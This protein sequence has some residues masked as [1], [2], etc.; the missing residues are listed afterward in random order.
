[1]K[2]IFRFLSLIYRLLKYA[3]RKNRYYSYQKKYKFSNSVS[4]G[5]VIMTG[6]NIEIG[7]NTY[8][9]SG[10]ISSGVKSKIKIGNWCAIGYNVKIIAITHDTIKS[11]GPVNERP[12]KER[13]IT[14]GDN[15]WI[16]SN[17][18]I[19]EGVFIEDNSIVGA[20]SLVTKNVKKDEIVGGV[21]AKHIKFKYDVE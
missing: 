20:N 5:D 7:N 3:D 1:M 4:L 16:G 18:F 21:P 14:I 15:V 13:D 12:I 8:I 17:V 11:T 9:N 2:L 10:E 6:D 19:K